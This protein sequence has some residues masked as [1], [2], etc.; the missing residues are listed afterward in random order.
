MGMFG[1]H[2][3]RLTLFKDIF[4]SVN[5]DLPYSVQAGHE[6]ISAGLMGADLLIL[7]KGKKCNAHMLVLSKGFAYNLSFLICNLFL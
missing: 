1:W 3:D 5:S 6:C 2:Y 4:L 7:V